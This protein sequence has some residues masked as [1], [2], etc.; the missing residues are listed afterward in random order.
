MGADSL[1]NGEL[2]VRPELTSDEQQYI[3]DN[4]EAELEIPDPATITCHGTEKG[5]V[6]YEMIEHLVRFLRGEN[7][8]PTGWV[9][10]P[11]F[12]NERIVHAVNG[13]IVADDGWSI[14]VTDGTV[15]DKM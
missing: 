1:F 8:D 15:T 11:P 3:L 5:S 6:Y 14:I 7:P 9:T 4:F 12:D 10:Y 2:T 13:T